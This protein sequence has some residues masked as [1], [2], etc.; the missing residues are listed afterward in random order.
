MAGLCEGGNEPPGSLKANKTGQCGLQ[1]LGINLILLV[2]AV[3]RRKEPPHVTYYRPTPK[4]NREAGACEYHST[5]YSSL[6][7]FLISGDSSDQRR[8]LQAPCSVQ[9][10]EYGEARYSPM[11]ALQSPVVL[12]VEEV[13]GGRRLEPR[14]LE[15]KTVEARLECG[16]AGGG[17]RQLLLPIN[18]ANRRRAGNAPES[19][20]AL[21]YMIITNFLGHQFL[22][23]RCKVQNIQEI[24][25]QRTRHPDKAVDLVHLTWPWSSICR[26]A[27]VR[28]TL[29][30]NFVSV[31]RAS[32]L[33]QIGCDFLH[34]DA[35]FMEWPPMSPRS[36]W[37]QHLEKKM[38]SIVYHF[39]GC[40]H[41][42][43]M[44]AALLVE[45]SKHESILFQ[46]FYFHAL[47]FGVGQESHG[48]S[49]PLFLIHS[50]AIPPA[51]ACAQRRAGI[52][53]LYENI[54]LR[55]GAT[56]FEEKYFS[57]LKL[58]SLADMN[59]TKLQTMN[60]QVV[61]DVNIKTEQ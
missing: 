36:V 24:P 21:V 49:S 32:G 43:L 12:A 23:E 40:R 1:V 13:C 22:I 55:H 45:Y 10:V 26:V 42:A 17:L 39:L 34:E 16:P 44:Y 11:F 51:L 59:K 7:D 5:T 28:H 9:V 54:M 15:R 31:Y 46:F 14:S 25:I 4:V 48:A 57:A 27:G 58:Q 18:Q 60:I 50:N 52:Q 20:P 8:A 47:H 33:P 30:V 29:P 3:K 35:S 38:V 37:G 2:G 19:T 41:S 61:R 53:E 56:N 6:L